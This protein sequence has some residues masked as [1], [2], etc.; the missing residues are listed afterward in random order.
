MHTPMTAMAYDLDQVYSLPSRRLKF[1]IVLMSQCL[2]SKQST[3]Y[4]TSDIGRSDERLS[5]A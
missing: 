1:A 4:S 5:A 2:G 3:S